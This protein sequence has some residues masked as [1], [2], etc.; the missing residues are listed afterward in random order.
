M[1]NHRTVTGPLSKCLLR[2]ASQ[3]PAGGGGPRQADRR[4]GAHG[5]AYR[6]AD[7]RHQVLEISPPV[8]M[9]GETATAF[10]RCVAAIEAAIRTSPAHW[11]YWFQT[12]DLAAL[13]LLPAT[14]QTGA[15][16]VR[17]RLAGGEEF[18]N[19]GQREAADSRP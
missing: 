16:A 2:A 19:P 18:R 12:D 7:C 13:G 6:S 11:F 1:P 8:P 9:Q 5:F 14:P 3:A 15:A 4:P 17:P 10:G